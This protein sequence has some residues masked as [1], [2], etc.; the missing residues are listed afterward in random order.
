MHQGDSHI[1]PVNAVD[2]IRHAF[3]LAGRHAAV[4]FGT[5]LIVQAAVL[6]LSFVAMNTLGLLGIVVWVVL[7][8]ASYQVS[9]GVYTLFLLHLRHGHPVPSAL[10]LLRESAPLAL[11]LIWLG[12]ISTLGLMLGFLLFFVPGVI[13]AL[14]WAVA[15]PALVAKRVSATEALSLSRQLTAGNYGTVF[16]LGAIQGLIANVLPQLL[17]GS[18]S[19]MAVENVLI[20]QGLCAAI[21]TPVVALASAELFLRLA[22]VPTRIAADA[23]LGGAPAPA[24]NGP[25]V[26]IPQSAPAYGAAA[27]IPANAYGAPVTH[28][29]PYGAPAHAAPAYGQAPAAPAHMYAANAQ[30]Q[31]QP[32]PQPTMPFAPPVQPHVVP[33]AQAYGAPAPQP[34]SSPPA[35]PAYPAPAAPLPPAPGIAGPPVAAQR[36]QSVGPPGMA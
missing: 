8:M 35:P 27:T 36:T 28:A 16:V 15:A 26:P 18:G 29:H 34:P 32:Q 12:I 11:P 19:T 20:V 33:T 14:R 4:V 7:M 2:I 13:L 23:P 3:T 10:Y 24:P 5:S 6:V 17:M 21:L 31:P 25:Y 9:M 30:P 22:R 1:G